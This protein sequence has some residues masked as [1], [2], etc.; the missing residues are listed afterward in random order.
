MNLKKRILLTAIFAL[1]SALGFGQ[2]LD[3][4]KNAADFAKANISGCLATL[5]ESNSKQPVASYATYMMLPSQKSL[6]FYLNRNAAHSHDLNRNPLAS[7]MIAQ[8]PALKPEKDPNDLPRVTFSG[9]VT[10]ISPEDALFPKIRD[11]YFKKFPSAQGY[12]GSADFHEFRFYV[13]KIEKIRSI[14]GFAKVYNLAE[15]KLFWEHFW[16]NP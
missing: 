4:Y 6:V 3:N 10:E 5:S 15:L 8:S 11:A 12:D 13:L 2:T 14:E 1:L 9:T 7:F 16:D